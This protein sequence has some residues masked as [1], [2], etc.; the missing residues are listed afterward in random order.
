MTVFASPPIFKY[1]LFKVA[2]RCNINCSY[3]YW[4]RDDA[5]YAKPNVLPLEVENLFLERLN[6]HIKQYGLN[7]FSILLHGGEPLLLGKRRFIGLLAK[8]LMIQERT[9]CSLHISM[10]SN[11][12]LIDDEWA[13]I[14][15]GFRVSVTIS[16]D[17]PQ[18]THD[19][20]RRDFRGDG[21]YDSVQQGI[22]KLRANDIEPGILAVCQPDNSPAELVQ[23]FVDEMNFKHFDV[24]VPDA[25]H[26]DKPA[27]IA[28]YYKELF[29]IWLGYN[30]RDI[31]IRFLNSVL[32]GL[33]GGES[34]SEAL[35]YGP[36]QT[37]SVLSDGS[38]EP[39]D[40]LRIAGNGSTHTGLNL[41]DH[42]FQD[43]TQ[44][45]V[46]MEAYNASFELCSTCNS[47][48]YKYA[49]GGGFLPH[50]WS[51]ENR[52]ENPSV[53]CHDLQEIFQHV[54]SRV[55]DKVEIQTSDSKIPLSVAIK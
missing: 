40:V 45:P 52:F 23:F 22:S 39:L 33:L 3:C 13:Q 15:A 41:L 24:L 9:E 36:I 20:Y 26:E 17:G 27:S 12:T 11:G 29:D 4:F 44:N 25:T 2:S 54:W 16:I 18:Q 1:L 35:G 51:S 47:C 48:V 37:V 8:L 55:I 50:R 6:Q 10:T 32:V 49:C 21:T 28:S 5:V 7:K 38:L 42:T 30:N 31:N 34:Y 43:L 53:Y 14:L 19:R 46:W